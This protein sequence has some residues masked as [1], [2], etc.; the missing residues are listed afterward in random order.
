METKMKNILVLLPVRE[1]HK[2]LLEEK[3]PSANFIYAPSREV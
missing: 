2:R 1:E 3:A